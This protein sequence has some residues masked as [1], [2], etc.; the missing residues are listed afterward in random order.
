MPAT[1]QNLVMRDYITRRGAQI[2]LSVGEY[3]FDKCFV[4]LYSM[5]RKLDEI[6]G[7]V[8]CSLFMLPPTRRDAAG[9]DDRFLRAA[10][11]CIA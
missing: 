3:Y 10:L 7:I 9:S 2:R 8:M 6:E 5:L 11:P 1:V 4:Q